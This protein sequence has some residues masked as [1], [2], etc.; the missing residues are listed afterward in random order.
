MVQK[1][2]KRKIL[3]TT[4]L[5]CFDQNCS[6]FCSCE[7]FIN[8]DSVFDGANL[9]SYCKNNTICRED[10]NGLDSYTSYGF[11]PDTYLPI[12]GN[13]F[14]SHNK[15]EHIP[16]DYLVSAL[17]QMSNDPF[18]GNKKWSYSKTLLY[19]A[20]DC[21]GLLRMVYKTFYTSSAYYSFNL[22]TLVDSVSCQR[23]KT[24]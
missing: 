15:T 13:T 20:V 2:I 5:Y 19:G 22:G 23:P 18:L 11:Y 21:N 1:C 3:L 7:Q 12:T 10:K 14:G 8:A 17:I 6:L 16:L 9:F 4:G 24:L